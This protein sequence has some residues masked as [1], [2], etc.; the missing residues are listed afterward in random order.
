LGATPARSGG[1]PVAALGGRFAATGGWTYDDDTASWAEVPRPN[2][3][4]KQPGAAVWADD[5]L[6]VVGGIDA[7][8]NGGSA[9][10]SGDAWI[11]QS[12][13]TLG[14]PLQ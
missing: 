5:R 7:D 1:W 3:A 12:G 2:D 11:S 6:V 13:E 9:S 14:R 10:L 4:P 8:R